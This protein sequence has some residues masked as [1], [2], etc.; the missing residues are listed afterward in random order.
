MIE[1]SKLHFAYESQKPLWE[2][3]SFSIQKGEFVALI[4]ENGSGKS[5]L[6][7]LLLGKLKPLSGSI[8]FSQKTG[9][10]VTIGYVPQKV[11]I[12]ATHPATVSELIIDRS[13]C[14]HLGVADL[15]SLQFNKLSGGQQQRVLVALALANDP[16][17]LLLDEPTV[18]VDLQT[19]KKFYEL[20]S[21]LSQK[22]QKTIVLVTHDV[23]LV[24]QYASRTLCIDKHFTSHHPHSQ[25]RCV[26]E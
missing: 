3:L 14:S 5:T 8:S 26:H 18:G 7:K 2:S 1:V 23:E 11:S 13:F 6:L 12:D 16:Q 17:I 9:K 22:H 4:G 24:E 10:Q 20:L 25:V 19:R 15:L 21:H